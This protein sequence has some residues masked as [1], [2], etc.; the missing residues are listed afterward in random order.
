MDQLSEIYFIA[1][2]LITCL[3]LIAVWSRRALFIR[4][5]AVALTAAFLPLSYAAFS[6]L[7]SKPKPVSLEWA[8]RE[9]KEA[10]VLAS[11]MEEN[12]AIY[13]WLS[14]PEADQ[15]RAYVLPWNRQ[16]AQQLQGANRQAQKTKS[17]VRMRRPFQV[18]MDARKELF[19]AAPQSG[20]PEKNPRDGSA[21]VYN[22]EEPAR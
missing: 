11:K 9:A 16:V 21:M 6:E 19:Y 22:R 5:G 13:V 18:S 7:L 10:T 4:L 14:F 3:G 8:H 12:V 2:A 20:G 1:L 17:K 15:P